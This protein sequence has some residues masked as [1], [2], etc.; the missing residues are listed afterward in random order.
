MVRHDVLGP[1]RDPDSLIDEKR[2]FANLLSSQPLCF[3]LFGELARD[4]DLAT[5]VLSKLAPG[6]IGRVTKIR[7]EHSPGRR[8]PRFT[9]DRSAFDV[10]VEYDS[11]VGKRGFLGVEVKYHEALNDAAAEHRARYD[12]LADAMGCFPTDRA[13]LKAKPLQQIWRDHLLSGALVRGFLGYDEGAFVFLYPRDNAACVRAL[14]AYRAQ[15]TSDATFVTW[16]L[17]DV[18]AAERNAGAPAAAAIAERYLDWAAIDHA[19]KGTPQR[20]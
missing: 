1:G 12:E 13:A 7:F 6:R 19:A 16:T 15:L 9:G 20:A 18:V 4:V 3:N 14:A 2:L 11:P 10:F 8:D 17:E 5:V